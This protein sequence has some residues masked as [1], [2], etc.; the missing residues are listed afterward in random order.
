MTTVRVTLAIVQ[1]RLR[2]LRR[3]RIALFFTFLLPLLLITLL[4]AAGTSGDVLVGLVRHDQGPLAQNVVD[5]LRSEPGLEIRSYSTDAQLRQAVERG[6]LTG[7]VVIPAD[8]DAALRAGLPAPLTFP[9]DPASQQSVAVR[10]RVSAVVDHEAAVIRSAQLSAARAG[11]FDAA[12]PLARR[13]AATATGG[14]EVTT[15]GRDPLHGVTVADY[16]TAGQLV[17]FVFL[18]AISGAGD[19]VETRRLGVT[20]RMLAAPVPARGIILGEGVGRFAIALLQSLVIVGL[21]TLLFRISWGD[22]L[23]VGAVVTAFALVATAVGLLVGTMARSNEQ[24]TSIGPPVGI[25]L[26]MLGGCMWPLEVV[27]S[28]M[29]DVGH[30]TPHAWALDAMVDLMGNRAGLGD[31][32][33]PIAMLLGFFLVLLSLAIW[34]LRALR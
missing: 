11:G 32:L 25:A 1:V 3:D 24:A 34:R 15:S 29:R 22:P 18:I 13:A 21:G 2:Q 10:S 19:L 8:Y 7:G 20:R 26:G 4:G 30:V 9:V 6:A 5:A 23:A 16:A 27:G 31:V 33:G 28:T 17:L 12:L 14:V